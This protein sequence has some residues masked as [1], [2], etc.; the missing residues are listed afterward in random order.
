M[1]HDVVD[2]NPKKEIAYALMGITG[3]LAMVLF[4]GVSAFLRPA[5]DHVDVKALNAAVEAKEAE[6]KAE[7]D[8]HVAADKANTEESAESAEAT[9]PENTD[10]DSAAK[11]DTTN[12]EASA[13][14]Q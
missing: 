6:A 12:T 13:P 8:A 9:T 11:T 14:A 1:A 4:I 7:T 10:K 2:N 5:G 3:F